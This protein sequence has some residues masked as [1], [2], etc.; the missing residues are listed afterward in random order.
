MIHT[1]Q[2]APT[3]F[4]QA[5]SIRFAYRRFGKTGGVLWSAKIQDGSFLN[6]CNIVTS[7]GSRDRASFSRL[8]ILLIAKR[9]SPYG[10]LANYRLTQYRSFR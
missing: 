8:G 3:Q 10:I 6:Q 5:N 9:V 2:T 1:H 7:R 4:V